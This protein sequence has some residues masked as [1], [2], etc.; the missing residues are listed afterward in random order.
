[1]LL[2]RD[3]KAKHT[4]DKEGPLDEVNPM[5]EGPGSKVESL[6]SAAPPCVCGM[7]PTAK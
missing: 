3:P 4:L 7:Y 2:E 5:A 6:Q 1:M